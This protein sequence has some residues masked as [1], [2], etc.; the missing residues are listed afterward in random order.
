MVQGV[1]TRMATFSATAKN[2]CITVVAALLGIAFQQHLPNLMLGAAFVVTSFAALDVYYLAQERRFRDFYQEVVNRPLSDAA[3]MDILPAKLSISKYL[4]GIR[5]FSTG[6]FYLLLLIVGMA[7]LPI[8]YERGQEA[9]LGD[10]R[11]AAGSTAQTPSV[12]VSASANGRKPEELDT[13]PPRIPE[14]A[15]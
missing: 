4:A 14:C 5:S 3:Q 6:G 2:F 9:G 7:L 1:V 12:A 11:C 8:M 10:H 15:K 13:K